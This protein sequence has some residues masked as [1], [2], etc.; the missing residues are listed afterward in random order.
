MEAVLDEMIKKGVKFSNLF[1]GKYIHLTI[2]IEI[3]IQRQ[4]M[5]GI[6]LCIHRDINCLKL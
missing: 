5:V 6:L 1:I 3:M 4:D 2:I